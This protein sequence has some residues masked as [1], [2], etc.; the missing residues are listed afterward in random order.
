M[1][2][3]QKAYEEVVAPY[4]CHS[5]PHWRLLLLAL[6]QRL[7]QEQMDH[8]YPG[9]K[10]PRGCDICAWKLSIKRPEEEPRYAA[11]GFVESSP[12][13]KRQLHFWLERQYND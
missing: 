1:S 2:L 13:T 8:L 5:E 6:F 4:G 11:R 12:S 7:L 10:I 9:P 3:I